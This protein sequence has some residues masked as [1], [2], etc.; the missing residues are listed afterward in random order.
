MHWAIYLVIGIVV[1]LII[2]VIIIVIM[3]QNAP[4]PFVEI[5]E[6]DSDCFTG[7]ECVY[8]PDFEHNVCVKVGQEYCK[9]YPYT[10]LIECTPG[11][12]FSPCDSCVNQPP[13]G[14]VVVNKGEVK[15]NDGGSEYKDGLASTQ[16]LDSTGVDL[17]VNIV[18][19]NGVIVQ[20]EILNSGLLYIE[21]KNSGAFG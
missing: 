6:S 5:C 9:I 1:L 13:F 16:A 18:T 3:R 20:A 7:Q 14:C 4:P 17:T 10:E 2:I 21:I 11:D 8:S 15:I 19:E 12:E